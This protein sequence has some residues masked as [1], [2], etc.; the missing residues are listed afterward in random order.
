[1]RSHITITP[2]IRVKKSLV[3]V[4]AIMMHD[5]ISELHHLNGA[6]DSIPPCENVGHPLGN[7]TVKYAEIM[8]LTINT[9]DVPYFR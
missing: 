6:C 5:F 9:A 7:G 4:A 2:V 8:A 1:M 3:S